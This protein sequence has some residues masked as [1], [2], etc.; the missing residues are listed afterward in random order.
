MERI[1]ESG[2]LALHEQNRVRLCKRQ[3]RYIACR[4]IAEIFLSLFALILFFPLFLTIS[5]LQK[6]SSPHESIFFLQERIG[7]NGKPFRIIKFRTMKSTAPDKV[8]T[9][10][11]EN[12]SLYISRLGA[13]LRRTSIDELPQLINVFKG[14]MSLIG[15]RPLIESEKEI[16]FLRWYYG[17]YAVPPGISGL[18]QVNGRD[19]VDIYNKVYFDRE[20]TRHIGLLLDMKILVQSV[21]VV[22]GHRGIRE[23]RIDLEERAVSTMRIQ[24]IVHEYQEE[25][26]KSA[27]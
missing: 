11:L 21:L 18:A 22:L 13:F 15:P 5:F 1:T 9:G 7:K 27:I 6:L 24:K 17:I 12:P 19:Y 20:Y 10:D 2:I 25:I 14:D 16:Q 23:G 4:R 3:E 26:L 8:A